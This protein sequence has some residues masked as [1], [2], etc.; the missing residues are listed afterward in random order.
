MEKIE[1]VRKVKE[2]NWLDKRCRT[3]EHSVFSKL[4]YGELEVVEGADHHIFPEKQGSS[5]L[6]GKIN[7]HDVS[8][9][10]TFVKGGSIGVAEAYIEG[11]WAAPTGGGRCR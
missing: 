2:A 11:K 8:V 9:Y 3:L 4:S 1:G 6:K 5:A 7:I 10:R